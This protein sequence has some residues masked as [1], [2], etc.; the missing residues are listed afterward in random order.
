LRLHDSRI[1]VRFAEETFVRVLV[2]FAH[3][4][5]SSFGAALH[6][7]VLAT[8]RSG[9]HE[10][11]D[12][13]LYAEG[14]DPVMSRQDR[15]DYHSVGVNRARVA[16]YVDRVLAAEALVLSYPVW[17]MGFPA[18]LKGFLDRVFLPGVSFDLQP[19][20]GFTPRLQNIKRLGAV[21]TYGGTRVLTMLMGDPPRHIVKRTLRALCAP[22]A[23][24]DYLAHYDMNHT[25][26]ERRAAFLK[27]VE[28]RFA[29]W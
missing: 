11:D 16:P 28:A 12:C 8:L 3:P 29:T 5:E 4:V 17:N 9:R 10:V 1:D 22:R 13:D 27:E 24:C 14:F 7:K 25:K 26:P 20:G 19:D 18:I 2:L 6:A 23:P 15:I 21:C